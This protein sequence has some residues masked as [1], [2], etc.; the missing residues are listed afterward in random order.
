MSAAASITKPVGSNFRSATRLQEAIT[1]PFERRILLWL[2]RRIPDAL[3]IDH[4]TVLG[5][6][7]QILAGVFYAL[8]R[9]NKYYLL[10][11]TFFIALNWLGDS[12]DGTLARYRNRLRP[13]YGFYV[14]HMADTFGAVFLMSGLALSG[15]LHWQVA[16]GMLVAFLVLSIESYLTTYTLG[17]FRMSYALFG[18]T[19]IRILLMIG[20]VALIFRPHAHLMGREFLLFD[21]GGAIAVAGM[22]GMAVIATVSHTARLYKEERLS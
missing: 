6:G 4:L 8:S 14:D 21:V 22:I 3:A 1:A 9:W 2:A 10:L 5:F 17:K 19:E 11:A 15:F 13:R 16:I 7:A 20:N 12:L 18:P